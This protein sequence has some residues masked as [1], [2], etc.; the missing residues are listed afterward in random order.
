[1][2]KVLIVLVLLVVAYGA[3]FWGEYHKRSA[4]QAEL[5]RQQVQLAESQERVRAG[6]LLGQL[7][8][9]KDAATARNYG[10]AQDLSTRFF[11]AARIE[12]GRV[13]Q[14]G[15]LAAAL[16]AVLG[17]RDAVTAALTRS[18]P[19]SVEAIEKA[20]MRL[21]QGLGYPVPASPSPAPP[22]AQPP[23][24]APAASPT[25]AGGPTI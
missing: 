3:G 21:R 11:D 15:G 23:T 4:V 18:D 20:E 22:A 16:E 25:P 5:D 12:A 1:M 24:P 6:E 13:T 14:S 8:N 10:Q 19:A 9:L 17:M 2:K 7:L